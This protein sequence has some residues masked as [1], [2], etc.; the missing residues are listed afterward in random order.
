MLLPVLGKQVSAGL[1]FISEP[2]RRFGETKYVINKARTAAIW[3][4]DAG[5]R[6]LGSVAEADYAWVRIPKATKVSVYLTLNCTAVE[7]ERKIDALADKLREI[8]SNVIVAKD[9]NA[10]GREWEMLTTNLRSRSLLEMDARLDL[11]EAST[12][13]TFTYRRPDF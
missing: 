13:R 6:I 1:L 5:I 7:S 2:L 12:G 3:I 8:T 11:V 10:K 4:C 9:F